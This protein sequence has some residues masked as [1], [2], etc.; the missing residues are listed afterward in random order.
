MI[1][2]RKTDDRRKART[3]SFFDAWLGIGAFARLIFI[4]AIIACFLWSLKTI[5]ETVLWLYVLLG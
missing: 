4:V 1:E 2:R 5:A 3:L